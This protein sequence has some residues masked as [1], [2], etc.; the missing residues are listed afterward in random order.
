[1]AKWK[2]FWLVLLASSVAAILS[3]GTLAA[4]TASTNLLGLVTAKSMVFQVNG[5]GSETQSLGVRELRPG[6]STA[7]EI[8]IDTSMTEVAMDVTLRLTASG[9]DLP[10]GVSVRLDGHNVGSS[11]NGT[12]TLS[13]K[14]MQGSVVKIPAMILWDITQD[15]LAALYSG[16]RQFT[17]NLSATLEAIQAR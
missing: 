3:A 13:Y 14:G 15:E 16:S 5:S 2:A 11:G 12:R 7:F 17:L 1:M 4:Y 9:T 8:A 6:E 10:P